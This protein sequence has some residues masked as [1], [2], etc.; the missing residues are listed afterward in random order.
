[1]D[2]GILIKLII[3]F[4]FFISVSPIIANAEII[5]KGAFHETVKDGDIYT[6]SI[7]QS[8]VYYPVWGGEIWER[9]NE[10]FGTV[11]CDPGFD[12]CQ[13]R[14]NYYKTHFKMELDAED[15]MGVEYNNMLLFMSWGHFK[16]NGKNVNLKNKIG[17]IKDNVV[18]YILA[19]KVWVEYVYL[20]DHVKDLIYINNSDFLEFNEIEIEFQ[21]KDAGITALISDI[22]TICDIEN[23]WICDT[24]KAETTPTTIKINFTRPEWLQNQGIIIDPE[25]SLT[26]FDNLTSN[27]YVWYDGGTGQ[28][29]R[30]TNPRGRSP[31]IAIGTQQVP[32]AVPQDRYYRAWFR[33]SLDPL[34]AGVTVTNATL[35]T[36]VYQ[37]S[38]TG[39][40]LVGK[41]LELGDDDYQPVNS[42]TNYLLWSDVL[43]GTNY[44]YTAIPTGDTIV[45]YWENAKGVIEQRKT[46]GKNLTVGLAHLQEY[47]SP[48]NATAIFTILYSRDATQFYQRPV[49][50]ITWTTDPCVPPNSGDWIFNKTCYLV[51]KVY[52]IWGNVGLKSNAT[53]IMDNT[54]LNL[55]QPIHNFSVEKGVLGFYRRIFGNNS[56]RIKN[57]P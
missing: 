19:P 8:P 4:I 47:T 23:P 24:Y 38:T 28:W 13:S 1:M 26:S 39:K 20:P 27:G 52:P 44:T 51:N 15:F 18:T 17:T 2:N 37:N 57:I 6:A 12:F 22:F 21:K 50:N 34:P 54:T 30:N 55:T 10:S 40:Y 29:G 49:F 25:I 48:T 9:I 46:E 3:G 5:D 7:Y 32:P 53:L 14:P 41:V 16:I 33:F 11:N 42:V 36:Y 56:A 43:N 45:S 35:K 31:L